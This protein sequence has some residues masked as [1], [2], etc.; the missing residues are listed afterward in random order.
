ML[1]L[2][3]DQEVIHYFPIE[4]CLDKTNIVENPVGMYAKEMSCQ[5]HIIAANSLMLKNLTNCFAK[6]HIEVNDVVLSIYAAGLNSLTEDEKKTGA[7]VID[8]GSHITSFAVLT[9]KKRTY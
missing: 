2:N 8:F 6:C 5:V 1:I 9:G 7:I 4:F 3:R